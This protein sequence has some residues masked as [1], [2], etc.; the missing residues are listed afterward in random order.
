MRGLAFDESPMPARHVARFTDTEAGIAG[1]LEDGG[2]EERDAEFDD[3]YEH[4]WD[5]PEHMLSGVPGGF[6][7]TWC[8]CAGVGGWRP[9][10]WGREGGRRGRE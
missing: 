9:E 7:K 5:M 1:D 4:A 2:V 8:V 3:G 10:G 6:Q